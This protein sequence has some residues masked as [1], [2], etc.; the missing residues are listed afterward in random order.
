MHLW[1]LFSSN[2]IILFFDVGLNDMIILFKKFFVP[3]SRQMKRLESI[4]RSP[5]Y[6]HFGETIQGSVSIRAYNQVSK[7]IF[8]R[9]QLRLFSNNN[10]CDNCCDKIRGKNNI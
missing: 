4:H 6:S 9:F 5:I 10:C 1:Y 2:F 7:L 8:F 3:T